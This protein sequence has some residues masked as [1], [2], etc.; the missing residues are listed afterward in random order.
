MQSDLQRIVDVYIKRYSHS[1]KEWKIIIIKKTESI[2]DSYVSL[3]FKEI[4]STYH[5][6]GVKTTNLYQIG[7]LQYLTSS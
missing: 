5:K 3:H 4:I 7:T 6:N 1:E 2:Q